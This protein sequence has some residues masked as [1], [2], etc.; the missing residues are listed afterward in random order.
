MF[1]TAKKD[2]KGTSSNK[3][4]QQDKANN[5][6]PEVLKYSSC[7]KKTYQ[8]SSEVSQLQNDIDFI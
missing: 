6:N 1:S 4:Q 8:L 2:L 7:Y 5:S 3:Y